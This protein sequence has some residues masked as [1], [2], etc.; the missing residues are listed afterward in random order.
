VVLARD[1]RR[2]SAAEVGAQ[3]GVTPEQQRAILNRARARLRERLAARFAR[4][5][6]GGG[7]VG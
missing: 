3:L 4:R 5:A 6:G 7:G 2:R 1:V